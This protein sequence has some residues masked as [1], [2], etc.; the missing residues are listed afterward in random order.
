MHLRRALL[1]FA[2]V[3]GVAALLAS[4]TGGARR[5]DEPSEPATTSLLPELNPAPATRGPERLR[6]SEGGK[7]ERRKL[8]PGRAAVVTVEVEQPGQ[9]ELVGLGLTA[10]AEPLTPARFDVLTRRAGR[11]EVRFMPVSGESALIGVL[12]VPQASR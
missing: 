7:R 4:L 9:V 1:L 2:V 11:Y 6:F 8:D 12:S 3:L 10:P 5:S